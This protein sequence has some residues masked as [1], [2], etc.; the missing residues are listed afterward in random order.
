MNSLS[1]AN[2]RQNEFRREIEALIN[3]HSRENVSNSRDFILA[4]YLANCLV[5][6]DAAVGER[7]HGRCSD[8]EPGAARRAIARFRDCPNGLPRTGGASA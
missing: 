1:S 4:E 6:F 3:H 2:D 8:G 5:T 7:W